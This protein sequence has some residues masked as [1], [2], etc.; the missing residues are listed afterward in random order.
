M[1]LLSYLTFLFCTLPMTKIHVHHSAVDEM[2]VRLSVFGSVLSRLEQRMKAGDG[3]KP[4][5]L[6]E[7]PDDDQLLDISESLVSLQELVSG[8]STISPNASFRS[9]TLLA[10]APSDTVNTE[11]GTN[12]A[13]G[14][15]HALDSA[16]Y[17][18]LAS[19]LDELQ[20]PPSALTRVQNYPI[21]VG[22]SA[23]VYKVKFNN[24]VCAAK[25]SYE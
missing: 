21:G 8:N 11:S 22:G 17:A 24:S 15:G 2:Q 13:N 10:S 9:S 1:L 14:F 18:K 19:T 5:V 25:V 6:T 12:G 7:L 3:R 16:A 20:V 4:S 23:K